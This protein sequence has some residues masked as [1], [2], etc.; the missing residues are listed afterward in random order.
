MVGHGYAL[1]CIASS[2]T[3]WTTFPPASP[4]TQRGSA[5]SFGDP[6]SLFGAEVQYFP[7]ST[8]DLKQLHPLEGRFLSGIF[9]GYKL[10]KGGGWI[11][12][13]QVINWKWMDKAETMAEL[14]K[15]VTPVKNGGWPLSIPLP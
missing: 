6:I 7:L 14:T 5:L 2:P 11:R 10:R 9:V 12:D 15:N 4:R 3:S 8:A 13:L 1:L